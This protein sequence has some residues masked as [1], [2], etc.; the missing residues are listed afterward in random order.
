MIAPPPM[1]S[2]PEGANTVRLSSTDLPALTC[3][4]TASRWRERIR[5]EGGYRSLIGIDDLNIGGRQLTDFVV[6]VAP[7]WRSRCQGWSDDEHTIA[8]RSQ[9][10]VSARPD[11]T[12]D[13]AMSIDG[14]RWPDA[15]HGTAGGNGVDEIDARIL[16][17]HRRLSC[18]GIDCG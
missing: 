17:E 3:R 16:R 7:R 9:I 12:V 13:V 15:G 6:E 2:A 10:G 4:R 18:L 5:P 1:T 8:P 14:D 11:T